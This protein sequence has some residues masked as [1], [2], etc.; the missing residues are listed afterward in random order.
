[1]R[2]KT[3]SA[4]GLIPDLEKAILHFLDAFDDALQAIVSHEFDASGARIFGGKA[5]GSF[6]ASITIPELKVAV[7]QLY[8]DADYLVRM[9][10]NEA[11]S[12]LLPTQIKGKLSRMANFARHIR[13]IYNND[14]PNVRALDPVGRQYLEDIFD[15]FFANTKSLISDYDKICDAHVPPATHPDAGFDWSVF[16]PLK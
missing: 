6:V 14:L 10:A 1:M 13:R 8:R 2:I 5:P 16:S 15:L 11:P 9:A 3:Y 12:R 7:Q 4:D